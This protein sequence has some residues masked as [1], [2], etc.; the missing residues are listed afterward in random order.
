MIGVIL[1]LEVVWI[2]FLVYLLIAFVR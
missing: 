1:V 2:L